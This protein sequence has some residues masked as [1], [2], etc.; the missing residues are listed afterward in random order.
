M[1]EEITQSRSLSKTVKPLYRG[2]L[3]QIHGKA[4]AA[5]FIRQGKWKAAK[6]DQGDE[7]FYKVSAEK[8]QTRTHK[9]TLRGD[10][11]H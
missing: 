5:R 4:E 2:E 10:R 8:T 6:D 3:E 1:P 7:V 11:R 9:K